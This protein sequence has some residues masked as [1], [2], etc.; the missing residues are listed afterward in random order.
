MLLFMLA[1]FEDADNA[2]CGCAGLG[3]W[4][5]LFTVLAT[6]LVCTGLKEGVG[7]FCSSGVSS[8]RQETA[9]RYT[10]SLFWPSTTI[11]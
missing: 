6:G 11:T 9:W 8:V 2:A 3:L 1:S 7:R 4:T 10:I 5:A